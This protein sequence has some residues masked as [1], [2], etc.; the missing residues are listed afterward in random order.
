MA[1]VYRSS[2]DC[3]ATVQAARTVPLLLLLLL[4]VCGNGA[5]NTGVTKRPRTRL[6]R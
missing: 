2:D 5:H 1:A 6:C 3:Y 4:A